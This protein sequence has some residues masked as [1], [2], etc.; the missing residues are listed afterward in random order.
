MS[1]GRR[2]WTTAEDEQLLAAIKARKTHAWIAAVLRRPVTSIGSRLQILANKGI[3]P[4]GPRPPTAT[5]RRAPPHALEVAPAGLN[6]ACCG[7]RDR[8]ARRCLCCGNEF[9]SAHAGNRMC[10][11]C[12]ANANHASP[13]AP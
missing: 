3:T 8:R 6:A 12:R 7:S 13:Y 9:S 5:P 11:R 4:F 1:R 10:V 2:L